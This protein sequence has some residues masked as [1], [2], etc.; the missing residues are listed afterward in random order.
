MTFL[1]GIWLVLAPFVLEYVPASS[2]IGAYWNDLVVG[3][4]IATL[5][6]VRTVAPSNVPWF[7]IVNVALGAWL[8]VA[9]FVHEYEGA[10]K[11]VMIGNDLAVGM[12][13]IVMA[14]ASAVS[15]HRHR[16]RTEQ[17]SN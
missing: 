8:I 3:V 14:A 7:S 2:G 16:S 17:A 13:V 9:P 11:G 6:I 4:A 10:N 15:T 1:A 5:A 12:V